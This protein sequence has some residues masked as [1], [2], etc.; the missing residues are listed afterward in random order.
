ML[1]KTTLKFHNCLIYYIKY[2]I[3]YSI[4]MCAFINRHTYSKIGKS[5]WFNFKIKYDKCLPSK[6]FTICLD[7]V[8]NMWHNR[9]SGKSKKRKKNVLGLYFTVHI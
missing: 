9:I 4:Y 3:E 7:E 1:A 2:N 8:E 6:Y 5:I